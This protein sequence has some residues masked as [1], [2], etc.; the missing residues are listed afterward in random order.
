MKINGRMI[1]KAETMPAKF[2]QEIQVK[3]YEESTTPEQMESIHKL[4]VA[5]EGGIPLVFFLHLKNGNVAILRDHDS[6][7]RYSNA[8]W[9][10][11]VAV[12]GHENVVAHIDRKP[13]PAPKR[14]FRKY[15]DE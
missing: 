10:N 7:V 11:L 5:N 13:K 9:D 12:G 1:Y 6:G 3:L 4:C 8:F 15:A 2:T 14:V